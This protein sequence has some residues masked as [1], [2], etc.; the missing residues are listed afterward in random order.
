MTRVSNFLTDQV[1]S[2][3]YLMDNSKKD[4]TRSAWNIC[5]YIPFVST[6]TGCGR[7]LLSLIHVVSSLAHACFSENPRAH[8]NEIGPAFANFFRGCMEMVPII[9]NMNTLLLDYHIGK[10]L[11]KNI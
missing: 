4:K 10:S 1:G 9:G 8:L 3:S 2:N 7:A 11:Q 6:I 5:G